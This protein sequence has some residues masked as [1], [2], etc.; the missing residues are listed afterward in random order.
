MNILR[1]PNGPPKF[2]YG[3]MRSYGLNV[4]KL[5]RYWYL[6]AGDTCRVPVILSEVR[7]WHLSHDGDHT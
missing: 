7:D 6:L 2:L 5:V 1:I 3:P 4:V